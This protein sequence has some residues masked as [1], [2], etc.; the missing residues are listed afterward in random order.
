MTF[1]IRRT[2]GSAGNSTSTTL[3]GSVPTTDSCAAVCTKTNEYTV[4]SC[5]ASHQFRF[6]DW[7][8]GHF[9]F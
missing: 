1:D 8:R 6:N 2:P 5:G 4:A 7:Q 3:Y 9:N